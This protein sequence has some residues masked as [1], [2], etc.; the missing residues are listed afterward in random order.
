LR[1]KSNDNTPHRFRGAY[2]LVL[3]KDKLPDLFG[4]IDITADT[5]P[6]MADGIIAASE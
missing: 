4:E 2:S 6:E 1:L 3:E 5:L